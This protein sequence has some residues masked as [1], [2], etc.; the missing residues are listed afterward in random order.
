MSLEAEIRFFDFL[1]KTSSISSIYKNYNK[2]CYN[3][4]VG[5]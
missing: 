5:Q 4:N 2:A 1:C 3:K